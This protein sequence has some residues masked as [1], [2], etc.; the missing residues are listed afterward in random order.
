MII[1][2]F[3][4]LFYIKIFNYSFSFISQ[5]TETAESLKSKVQALEGVTFVKA[6]DLFRTGFA[7]PYT[8]I[9][10]KPAEKKAN[11]EVCSDFILVFIIILL[12]GRSDQ[13]DDPEVSKGY[14]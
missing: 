14:I 13:L 5:G 3:L 1:C 10:S 7:G 8:A 9:S 4:H 2:F 6:V 12:L 11:T